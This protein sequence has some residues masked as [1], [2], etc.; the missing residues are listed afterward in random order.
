M[1]PRFSLRRLPPTGSPELVGKMIGGDDMLTKAATVE[2][3]P[4]TGTVTFSPG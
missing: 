2:D 1:A 4:I 3:E